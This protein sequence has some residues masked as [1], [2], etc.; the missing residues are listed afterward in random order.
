MEKSEGIDIEIT[1]QNVD[2]QNNEN[3]IDFLMLDL[4]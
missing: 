1:D 4:K 3:A 2:P